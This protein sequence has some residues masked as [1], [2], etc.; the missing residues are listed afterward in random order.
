MTSSPGRTTAR[1]AVMIA[2]VAPAVMVISVAGSK[3]RPYMA[4]IFAATA[5][6]N[7]GTPVIGG[8]W[9]RPRFIA[10]LTASTSFGSHSKS[11]NP[12]PR[13]TAP[14]S[15]ASADITVKIVVPT[16]GSLVVTEGVRSGMGS[17]LIVV[18]L[19]SHGLGNEVAIETVGEQLR[20]PVDEVAEVGAAL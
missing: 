6:R 9:L 20:E 18:R 14:V 4:S 17:E 15:V 3:R 7:A 8:Y 10:S 1:T 12:W 19:A 13:F 11:G 5:S 16:A 2:W